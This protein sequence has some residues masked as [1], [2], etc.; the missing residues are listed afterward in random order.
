MCLQESSRFATT[1]KHA[2]LPDR[3]MRSLMCSSALVVCLF[4]A[5]NYQ[6]YDD[7]FYDTDGNY[8]GDDEYMIIM[9]AMQIMMMMIVGMIVMMMAI[10]ITL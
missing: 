6:D 8:D 1:C 7:E 5:T 10:M 9:M 4:P 3:G 2:I